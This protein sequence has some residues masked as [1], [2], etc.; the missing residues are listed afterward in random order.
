MTNKDKYDKV[1]MECFSLE[2]K[3]LENDVE[4]NS[5]QSWDSI[6][7]MEMI[8]ELEDMFNIMMETD[9]VINFSSY[10]KGFEIMANY[11]IKI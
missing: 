3:E 9:D 11:G 1:F 2:K 4:Y 7:H 6:G 8:A 10:K 5:I